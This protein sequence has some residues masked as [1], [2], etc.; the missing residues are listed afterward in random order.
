MK[1]R[2]CM[3]LIAALLLMLVPRVASANAPIPWY[4]EIS[5]VNVDAG[6]QIA[7]GTTGTIGMDYESDETSFYLICTAPDG[8]ETR[9]DILQQIVVDPVG[10]VYVF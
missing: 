8:T 2:L 4:I 3:L 9:T 5:C 6:T 10:F 1:K 7:N